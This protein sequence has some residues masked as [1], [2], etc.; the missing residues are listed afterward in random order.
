MQRYLPNL[1]WPMI[2]TDKT[3]KFKLRFLSL[4]C[5]IG[6]PLSLYRFSDIILWHTYTLQWTVNLG[7]QSYNP[8]EQWQ[9]DT[10]MTLSKFKLFY[11]TFVLWFWQWWLWLSCVSVSEIF[12]RTDTV[13]GSDANQYK[14]SYHLPCIYHHLYDIYCVCLFAFF[15]LLLFITW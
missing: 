6:S 12:F 14:Y 9:K 5:A 1:Y 8:W 11:M 10:I 13:I 2:I 4:I 7:I 15:N 3:Q